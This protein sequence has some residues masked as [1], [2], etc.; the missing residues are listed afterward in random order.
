MDYHVTTT[1]CSILANH[2]EVDVNAIVAQTDRLEVDF[3]DG[4]SSKKVHFVRQGTDRKDEIVFSF[5]T[6]DTVD[7]KDKKYANIKKALDKSRAK[8]RQEVQ[9]KLDLLKQSPKRSDDSM[10]EDG[11]DVSSDPATRRIEVPFEN[12]TPHPIEIPL[13]SLKPKK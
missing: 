10:I 11:N 9:R 4:A 1:V 6:D 2:P 5:N 13:D 12:L 7:L 8:Q 3:I